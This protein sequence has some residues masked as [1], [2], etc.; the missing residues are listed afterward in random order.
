MKAEDPQTIALHQMLEQ[1]HAWLS[2][3]EKFVEFKESFVDFI[4]GAVSENIVGSIPAQKMKDFWDKVKN[5]I[6]ADS[7]GDAKM[8]ADFSKLVLPELDEV[9]SVSV[10]HATTTASDNYA[11]WHTMLVRVGDGEDTAIKLGALCAIPVIGGII[12]QARALKSLLSKDITAELLYGSDG[13]TQGE[14]LNV[15]RALRAE[16]DSNPRKGEIVCTN[17]QS[18]RAGVLAYLNTSAEEVAKGFGKDLQSVVDTLKTAMEDEG[19]V[20]FLK[21]TATA[22][23]EASTPRL[24]GLA[25]GEAARTIYRCNKYLETYEDSASTFVKTYSGR[26]SDEALQLIK[27][28]DF[29]PEKVRTVSGLL[30]A[31]QAMAR[32]LKAG[33]TRVT[34]LSK[35][36]T[37]LTAKGMWPLLPPHV[38]D[39]IVKSCTAAKPAISQEPGSMPGSSSGPKEGK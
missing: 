20:E 14:I 15:L 35:C 9:T 26:V 37:V 17:F 18:I 25:G 29:K 4:F 31:V 39:R 13:N 1:P 5:C 38:Q 10:L 32:P 23:P 34:L 6:T 33:E 19:N 27:K 7:Q 21:V 16:L 30:T 8:V 11:A 22:W 2:D 24:V 12:K 28:T 36:K 3:L